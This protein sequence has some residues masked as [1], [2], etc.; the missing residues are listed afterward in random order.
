MKEVTRDN[1]LSRIQNYLEMGGLFNPE[2]MEH[3][4]VQELIFDMRSYLQWEKMR[5]TESVDCVSLPQLL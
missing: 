4:K 2:M 5:E 1:L 3:K